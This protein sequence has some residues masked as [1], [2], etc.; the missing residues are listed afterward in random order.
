MNPLASPKCARHL[1]MALAAISGIF[2]TVG[3]GSG[4]PIIPP[5]NNGFTNSNFTGT[6]VLSISGTDIN[7]QTESFFTI[8]GAITADGMGNI[9]G[10]TVDINDPNIGGV[11]TGQTVSKSTYSVSQDGR[12]TGSLVTP[13]GTFGMDFVLTSNDHGLIIRFDN[14]GTGSG[15]LDAQGTAAQTSLQSLA[16]SLSGADTSQ[17]PL[18]T[19]GGFTLNSSGTIT[20]G[21]EDLNDSGTS[22]GLTNLPLTGSVVLTSGTAGTAEFDSDF[23]SLFFDVWVIDSSHLKLIETD[24]TGLALS[25]DAFPQQTSFTPGQL[26]FTFSGIDL[27]GDPVAAGGYVTTDANGTLTNGIEDYNNAGSP[28]TVPNFTGTCSASAPFVN[29]RC[30]LSTTGFTNGLAGNL[31]FAAYPSSAGILLLQDDSQGLLQGTANAQTATAF[32]APLGYALNLAGTNT[33]GQGDV[34]E[35]DDIAQFNATTAAAPATNM[36]GV[37]DENSILGGPLSPSQFT[38]SYAPDSPATGRGSMSITTPNTFIGG[39]SLEYYVVNG[40]TTLF[41]EGD[42]QQVSA[43][44]FEAQSTPGGNAQR[45]SLGA[46]QSP[47]AITRPVFHPRHTVWQQ[48]ADS[49]GFRK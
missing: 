18:G 22:A 7:T 20:S 38:G 31:E 35:V 29:G 13:Q 37:L 1:F 9:T 5:N 28:N 8:V 43:G 46:A 10:G 40:S 49:A 26:V 34:G 33:D 19:V 24:A 15:T 36:T 32:T 30:Q 12:G 25:G 42:N 14:N 27:S 2:L 11:F 17:S 45:A 48:K 44:I 41:I 39:L 16:F 4:N 21:V 47:I 23:G 3:C 6:Y